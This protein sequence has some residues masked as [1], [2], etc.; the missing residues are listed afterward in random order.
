MHLSPLFD[1]CHSCP[2]TRSL[3]LF[4]HPSFIPVP[5]MKCIYL[6]LSRASQNFSLRFLSDV[7]QSPLIS[8]FTR[9]VP[10]HLEFTHHTHPLSSP[11]HIS[12]SPTETYKQSAKTQMSCQKN[13]TLFSETFACF[14][15]VSLFLNEPSP[16][17]HLFS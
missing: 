17:T 9:Q 16:Q 4:I 1:S 13:Q 15:S 7:S 11:H 2:L 14:V 10:V 8:S 6:S 12:R 3:S 5:P